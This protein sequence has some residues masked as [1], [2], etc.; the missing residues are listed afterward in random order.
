MALVP[1]EERA[2]LIRQAAE[3]LGIT[4]ED[5]IAAAMRRAQVP[6]YEGTV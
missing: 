4:N 2:E 6:T 3:H 1:I 5:A